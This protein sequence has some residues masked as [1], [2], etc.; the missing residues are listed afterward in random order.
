MLTAFHLFAADL[1]AVRGGEEKLRTQ[2][3]EACHR[4]RVLARRLAH[5]D[6][7]IHDLVVGV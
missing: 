6:H 5:K 4:E 1:A 7:E 3:A 2:L